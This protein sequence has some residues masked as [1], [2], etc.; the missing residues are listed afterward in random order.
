[1][2]RPGI[3]TCLEAADD[4][5]RELLERILVDEEK[6]VDWIEA[7]LHQINEIGTQNYLTTPTDQRRLMVLESPPCGRLFEFQ[8]E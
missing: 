2:L 6:H 3:R 8:Q 4:A 7:Q 1:M 5:S